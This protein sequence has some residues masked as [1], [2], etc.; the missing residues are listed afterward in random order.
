MWS[1]TKGS[2]VF[3]SVHPGRGRPSRGQS[4]SFVTLPSPYTCGLTTLNVPVSALYNCLTQYIA[5]LSSS[6]VMIWLIAPPASSRSMKW[7]PLA[8]TI[9]SDCFKP[10]AVHTIAG[11]W[12][13]E[14][15]RT[16]SRLTDRAESSPCRSA[17]EQEHPSGCWAIRDRSP[18]RGAPLLLVPRFEAWSALTH[19]IM[20]SGPL[21]ASSFC[22][23]CVEQALPRN[24]SAPH[25]GTLVNTARS[26]WKRTL[27]RLTRPVIG[28]WGLCQCSKRR[29]SVK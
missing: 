22:D 18:S 7:M 10:K 24:F 8:G 13:G 26:W 19:P 6:L 20:E 14:Q 25:C 12:H 1:Q 21:P 27:S 28:T 11:A 17:F 5:S 15:L 9:S 2:G 29:A 4:T 3:V 23:G 16:R